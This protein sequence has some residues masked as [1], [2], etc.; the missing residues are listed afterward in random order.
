MIDDW[1]RVSWGRLGWG[2]VRWRNAD[3]WVL[4]VRYGWIRW[5]KMGFCV[6]RLL[7]WVVSVKFS[8]ELSKIWW[9]ADRERLCVIRWGKER[10]NEL[11]WVEENCRKLTRCLVTFCFALINQHLINNVHTRTPNRLPHSY[12]EITS[13]AFQAFR[14]PAPVHEINQ[15]FP[16][17]GID[18]D[19]GKFHS[20]LKGVLPFYE[21]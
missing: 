10:S 18:R 2:E 8:L 17:Y 7:G 20:V 6:L 21:C 12:Y 16:P 5:L 1:G 14:L 15:H 3:R 9:D 19:D 4:W 11:R 13:M